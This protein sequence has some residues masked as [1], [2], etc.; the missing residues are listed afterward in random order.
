MQSIYHHRS[1]GY[2]GAVRRHRIERAVTV[3]GSIRGWM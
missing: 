1:V 2:K 3:D